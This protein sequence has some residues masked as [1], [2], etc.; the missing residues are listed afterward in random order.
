MAKDM[1]KGSLFRALITFSVPLILS[2]MLQQFYSWA[3]AFIVGNIEGETALAAIGATGMIV[4]LFISVING[5]T[6]GISI[7]AAQKFGSGNI[8]IQKKILYSFVLILGTIFI[9]LSICG[10]LFANPRCD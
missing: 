9:G 5:F 6:S 8:E 2:G 10:F 3:D 1:T 4:N 7:L